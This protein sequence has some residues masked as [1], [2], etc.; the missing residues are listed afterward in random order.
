MK[1]KLDP[2][3]GAGA[4][5]LIIGVVVWLF[6]SMLIGIIIGV[7][8]LVLVGV[9][10]I[11]SATKGAQAPMAQPPAA[12]MPVAQMP[13]APPMA[14]PP[15]A[16]MPVAQMP[17]APPP[18]VQAS[19]AQAPLIQAAASDATGATEQEAVTTSPAGKT[20]FCTGCG[21]KL[22][23]GD[24]FCGSCGRQIQA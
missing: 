19:A 16:Q 13:V 10:L 17:V 22:D 5:L 12:Q 15:A 23:T 6:V 1:R 21:A 14:Q 9:G 24:G 11:L 3:T 18:A 2:V 7:I 8:G 4:I 20:K